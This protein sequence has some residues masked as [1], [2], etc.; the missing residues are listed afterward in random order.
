MDHNDEQKVILK[1]L[2]LLKKETAKLEYRIGSIEHNGSL[3]GACNVLD[4]AATYIVES[5]GPVLLSNIPLKTKSEADDFEIKLN[6]AKFCDEVITN[7]T[8]FYGNPNSTNTKQALFSIINKI[9]SAELLCQYTWT[10]KSDPKQK[11]NKKYPFKNMTKILDVVLKV[12]QQID[13]E[14]TMKELS[15]DVTYKVLK[16]AYKF[17]KPNKN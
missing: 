2:E 9:F 4:S 15:R 10:G 5:Q 1:S 8:E 6:D 16:Y 12:M 3:F 11:E 14:Y 17:A 7:M 13:A